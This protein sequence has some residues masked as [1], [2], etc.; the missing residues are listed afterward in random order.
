MQIIYI[1]CQRLLDLAEIECDLSQ[2]AITTR[3][4]F[5]LNSSFN[6]SSE[7]SSD[8]NETRT[9]K[10]SED[11]ANNTERRY[12]DN[13]YLKNQSSVEELNCKTLTSQF[14]ASSSPNISKLNERQFD[15]VS[16]PPSKKCGIVLQPIEM[17]KKTK[18]K[19]KRSIQDRVKDIQNGNLATG[20][21]K[22]TLPSIT[23]PPINQENDSLDMLETSSN[24]LYKERIRNSINKPDSLSLASFSSSSN[25]GLSQHELILKHLAFRSSDIKIST[26]IERYKVIK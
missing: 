2:S 1:I 5:M 12:S 17:T 7:A 8:T 14:K 11:I 21:D 24:C 22:M 13:G 9:R 20:T 4:S 10:L 19:K 25:E 26:L 3:F 23:L 18:K 16:L 6:T 15:A